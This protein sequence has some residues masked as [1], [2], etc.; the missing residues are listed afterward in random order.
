MYSVNSEV[1][2]DAILHPQN[3]PIEGAL[4]YNIDK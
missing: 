2:W 4:V 1:V 3:I